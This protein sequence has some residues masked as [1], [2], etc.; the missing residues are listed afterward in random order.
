MKMMINQVIAVNPVIAM[1][2]DVMGMMGTVEKGIRTIM[3]RIVKR[4]F[5]PF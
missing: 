3:G 1:I 2:R 5:Q 4:S